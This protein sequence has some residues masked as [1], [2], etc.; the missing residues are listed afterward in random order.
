MNLKRL[1][2]IVMILMLVLPFSVM[3][4]EGDGEGEEPGT[5]LDVLGS[6]SAPEQE[7]EAAG[8]GEMAAEL[9]D[10]GGETVTVAVENAYPPFNFLDDDGEPVGWDYDTVGEICERLNCVPEYIETSWDGMILAV[11]EGEY[12]VAADGI[13]IT[14]ERK[15]RVD[16]SDG[17]MTLQQVMLVH[18][19][20][21][22]FESVDEFLENEDLLVG[23]QGGT[24]NFF[25]A[26]E[27]L[28][29]DSERIIVFETFPIAVQALIAG[30]V[31]G[32]IMDDVAGQGYVGANPEDVRI[33]EGELTS[34]EELGFIFP[35]GSELRDAFN[36]A[37][38]SMRED[39]TL[40]E[41]TN[42]WF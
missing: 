6:L 15:E 28:G 24:T 20:E 13:T 40:Q 34:L 41:I 7:G 3:A 8:E 5:I 29:E 27:L 38:D 10:L 9:P 21:D 18:V 32:V 4:Q 12:D 14:E 25:T 30:D 26:T 2:L 36:A 37:L 17:Y 42:R 23:V 19:G 1:L 22:R 11:S 33:L 35:P 31:D 16:F 39:G